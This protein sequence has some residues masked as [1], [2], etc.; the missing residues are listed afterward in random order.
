M[1]GSRELTTLSKAREPWPGTRVRHWRGVSLSLLCLALTLGLSV[2]SGSPSAVWNSRGAG[3][4]VCERCPLCVERDVV[5]DAFTPTGAP[6]GLRGS[7][8]CRQPPSASVT[9]RFPIFLWE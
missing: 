5:G 7:F 8:P 4:S 6:G 9:H 2:G 1:G 3:M